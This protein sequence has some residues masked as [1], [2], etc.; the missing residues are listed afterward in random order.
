M[1][2]VTFPDEPARHAAA[3]VAP[4]RVVEEPE[5][6]PPADRAPS[7]PR[8]PGWVRSFPPALGALLAVVAIAG[9][10]W[11]V[12]VP[13]WQAPDEPN[14]FAYAQS[15]ATRFALPGNPSRPL[16]FSLDE[17]IAN[18]AVH[19]NSLSFWV[20]SMRPDWSP[21]D[22]RSYLATART[23]PSQSDGGGPNAEA[24][25]P[26]LFYL[27]SDLAY[28]ASGS[29]NAFGRLYAMR[30]WGVSLLLATVIAAWLLAGEVFDRRRLP[31]L[32]CA[33]VCGLV[34]METFM[35]TSINPDALM[36]P[37]WTFALWL[38]T[39]LI[40]RGWNTAQAA[41]LCGLT[42]A[43]ILT[44][45]TSYALVAPVLLALALAWRSQPAALRRARL[46]RMAGPLVALGVPVLAWVAF[47]RTQGRS[48]V[49]SVAAP[50]GTGPNAGFHIGGFFSYLWQFYLPRLPFLSR[51]DTTRG[52][53]VFEVWVKEGW[54][55]FG[56]LDVQLPSW[57]YTVLGAIT[58]LIAVAGGVLLAA[59]RA[60]RRPALLAFF[61]LTLLT[62]LFGLHLTAYRSIVGGQGALLQGRYL[63]PVIGLLGLAVALV[64][65]RV[66]PRWRGVAAGAVLAGLL[67]LQVL[68]L[69]TVAKVYYT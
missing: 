43:A 34:P 21:Q 10:I 24:N 26:P 42:A 5:R 40:R 64:V 16:G 28:W 41:G 53:A 57:T 8:R 62:L 52:L 37:L 18:N 7:H 63:L 58:A 12:I 54:A 49:N 65:R 67:L 22:F 46:Q 35:A 68:S 29:D 36:V 19:A 31:Q 23:H 25:N 4:V 69:A 30:V 60:A 39:R 9:V 13:P 66:P 38:G 14:H 20:T 2:P 1:A 6:R 44:K 56:W 51:I 33:A 15:L 55:T 47:T 17:A 45:A 59:L 3:T 32:V 61:G 27:F 11:A 48:A 50:A